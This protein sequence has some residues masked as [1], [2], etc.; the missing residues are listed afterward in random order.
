MH[1]IS[2][3]HM[4]YEVVLMDR[5]TP[6]QPPFTV[7]GLTHKIQ[8]KL[9]VLIAALKS[10]SNVVGTIIVIVPHADN[11]CALE[12]LLVVLVIFC[13]VVLAFHMIFTHHVS[14]VDRQPVDIS[15]IPSPDKNVW[16][17]P[18]HRLEDL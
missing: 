12:H 5:C 15:C 16:V 2:P 9:A 17:V 7:L 8:E 6:L 10:A 14:P 3:I 1:G 18:L 13:V 4:L 11:F